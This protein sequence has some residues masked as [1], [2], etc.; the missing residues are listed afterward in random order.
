MFVCNSCPYLRGVDL[1]ELHTTKLEPALDK[2][3]SR[4]G[5]QARR[6]RTDALSGGHRA[7]AR[8]HAF[9]TSRVQL[10]A[11]LHHVDG[12]HGG[13]RDR[14]ADSARQ[15]SYKKVNKNLEKI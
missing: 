11:R 8:Q 4:S 6:Q 7:Q 14:A 15:R 12:A 2:V 9:V 13:V 1:E 3:T 10:H 5:A